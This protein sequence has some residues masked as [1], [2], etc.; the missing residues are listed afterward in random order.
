MINKGKVARADFGL[1]DGE[2]DKVDFPRLEGLSILV[3]NDSITLE[4]G[5]GSGNVFL[6]I[7][8]GD[9]YV[10]TVD[11]RWF[12]YEEGQN[13]PNVDIILHD[14]LPEEVGDILNWK[15]ENYY[16]MLIRK[17]IAPHVD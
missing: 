14:E 8:Q 5:N 15:D 12:L 7:Y 11:F 4:G 2:I 13:G 3:E 16:R 10:G 17:D 6:D 9:E 1:G